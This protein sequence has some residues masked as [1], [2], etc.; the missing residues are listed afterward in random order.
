MEWGRVGLERGCASASGLR[1]SGARAGTFELTPLAVGAGM[2]EPVLALAAPA[3]AKM[4]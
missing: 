4:P 2:G 3:G 1:A